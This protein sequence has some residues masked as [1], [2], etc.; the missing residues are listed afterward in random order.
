MAAHIIK[1]IA[2]KVMTKGASTGDTIHIHP[3]STKPVNFNKTSMTEIAEA[4]R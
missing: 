2:E 1:A 3:I 4:I